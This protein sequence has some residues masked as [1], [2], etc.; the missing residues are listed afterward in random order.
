MFL[1]V[2]QKSKNMNQEIVSQAQTLLTSID[3]Q[4][5]AIGTDY[6]DG[7][8]N[9]VAHSNGKTTQWFLCSG[10]KTTYI[11]KDEVKDAQ[12]QTDNWA[13]LQHLQRLR[14][15]LVTALA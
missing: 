14:S 1:E 9:E 6:R 5:K 15:A 10:G 11:K 12:R 13:E 7:T 2:E 4:I 8:L 3:A